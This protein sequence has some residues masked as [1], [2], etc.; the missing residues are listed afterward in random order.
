ME[1]QSVIH[2]LSIYGIDITQRLVVIPPVVSASRASVDESAA[3]DTQFVICGSSLA[4]VTLSKRRFN[5]C[6]CSRSHPVDRL[7]TFAL[8]L[9][10]NGMYVLEGQRS[11]K[12]KVRE[13]RENYSYV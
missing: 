3:P 7:H 13:F 6:S 12:H 4:V 11:S 5:F 10:D 9:A 8:H 2:S 1:L